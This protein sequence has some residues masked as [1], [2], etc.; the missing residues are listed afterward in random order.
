MDNK[1]QIFNFGDTSEND[2]ENYKDYKDISS[3]TDNLSIVDKPKRNSFYIDNLDI[4]ERS[5]T[6]RVSRKVKTHIEKKK[7]LI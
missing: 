1:K 7:F 4:Y 2:Q 5:E 3:Q 6:E